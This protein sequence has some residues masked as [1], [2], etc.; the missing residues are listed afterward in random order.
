M[1]QAL[2]NTTLI[3]FLS[4]VI[5][6]FSLLAPW[7]NK[8]WPTSMKVKKLEN[9]QNNRGLMG[10]KWS[11]LNAPGTENPLSH[12]LLGLDEFPYPIIGPLG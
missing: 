3:Q 9:Y 7:V 10:C 4:W 5:P 8:N 2:E 1:P 6:H 11:G 12:P